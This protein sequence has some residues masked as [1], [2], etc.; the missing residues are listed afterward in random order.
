[1]RLPRANLS[2][3]SANANDDQ[4]RH[5]EDAGRRG[6]APQ[7]QAQAGQ[8]VTL[9][10]ASESESNA[11][12]AASFD[13]AGEEEFS[14][15]TWQN[16]FFL[17]PN[18]RFTRTPD[19][20]LVKRTAPQVEDVAPGK[21]PAVQPVRSAQPARVTANPVRPTPAVAAAASPAQ[22]KPIAPAAVPTPPAASPQAAAVPT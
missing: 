1:M 14:R 20:D 9:R 6:A 7:A 3:A 12:R 19:T 11:A 21:A 10:V 8:V 16:Y 15:P 17:A 22:A 4:S 18:V 13:S 5:P 2:G